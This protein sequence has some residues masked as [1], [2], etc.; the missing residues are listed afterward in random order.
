MKLRILGYDHP[1]F[2]RAGP[3]RHKSKRQRDCG[4]R[5]WSPAAKEARGSQQPLKLEDTKSRFSPRVFGVGVGLPTPWLWTY[6]IHFCHSVVVSHPVCGKFFTASNTHDKSF[7]P[8]AYQNP[9]SLGV[10]VAQLG[11]RLLRSHSWFLWSSTAKPCIR[12]LLMESL[13]LP[14][15]SPPAHVISHK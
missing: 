15:S 12:L 13:L 4:G 10:W 11:K 3:T 1:R 6:R 5:G 7:L 14:L 8:V 2:P 9:E